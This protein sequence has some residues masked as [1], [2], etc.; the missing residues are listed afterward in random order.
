M[1]YA[2]ILYMKVVSLGVYHQ[3]CWG[4]F[5][6]EKFPEISMAESGPVQILQKKDGKTKV[7]TCWDITAQD[8]GSLE[9]FLG[10][11]RREKSV[12]EVVTLYKN[13]LN[14]FIFTRWS[15]PSSS[16]D[17]V[18]NR[19]CIPISPVI[20]ENGYEKFKI[21][22]KNPRE[23]NKLLNELNVIGE[24]KVYSVGNFKKEAN[25]SNLTEK[26]LIALRIAQ[27]HGYYGWPR[28]VT[29]EGLAEIAK[30][31]R[32]AFQENL[33]KAEAKVFPPTI[34]GLKL[35]VY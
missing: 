16:Y 6:P 26:Q 34:K 28:N 33:R 14:A 2:A 7:Q 17:V 22:T 32:R 4:S 21:L 3:D 13:G 29:L 1:S 27:E 24:S 20:Q 11:L 15:S 23:I 25:K 18:V 9:V 10:E 35:K 19:N 12:K 8:P 31:S 30:T 5:L